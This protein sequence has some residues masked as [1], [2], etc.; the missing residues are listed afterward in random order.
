MIV[1]WSN[2]SHRNSTSVLIVSLFTQVSG[3]F[4]ANCFYAFKTSQKNF[5]VQQKIFFYGFFDFVFQY[6]ILLVSDSL[7][8]N[9]PGIDIG[10]NIFEAERFKSYFEF[11]HFYFVVAPNVY[12]PE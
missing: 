5:Y 6:N 12:P 4:F 1:G 2:F 9:I 7:K 8:N 10:N 3:K 11:F